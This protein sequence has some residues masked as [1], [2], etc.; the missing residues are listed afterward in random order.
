MKINKLRLILLLTTLISTLNFAQTKMTKISLVS[1]R[2]ELNSPVE[3]TQMSD[4]MWTLKY[5][6]KS[7]PILMLS[8]ENA[9]VNLI[10]FLTNQPASESQLASFK[11]FQI[12]QLKKSRPDLE[13]LEQ[14]VKVVNEKKVGFF[15]FKTQAID[16]KVFNYYFFTVVD[17]KIILFTF[18]C[19]EN[20]QK[21]WEK[22][23][24]EIVNTIKIK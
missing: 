15:K 6:N 19:I 2:V 1:G 13:V 17:G 7:K 5:Q 18:N 4:E 21:E 3:L 23:A 14:G 24:D 12:T 22:T 8:D 11:D 16:Q 9:E 10:G 20:L